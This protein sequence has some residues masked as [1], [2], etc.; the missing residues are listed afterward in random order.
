[1][2]FLF[3]LLIVS[4]GGV[5]AALTL[6]EW[7]DLLFIAGPGTIVSLIL[8]QITWVR[9]SRHKAQIAEKWV[10]L[11]GSNVMYWKDETPQIAT[12]LEVTRDLSMRGFTPAVIF[13]ASAGYRIS[14]KYLHDSGFAL[15]LGLPE[16]RVMVVP[17]GTPADPFILAVA[18]DH[19]ARVV[20]NDKYRDWANGFPQVRNPGFLIKGGFRSGKL[21][22]DL[23]GGTKQVA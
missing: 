5:L 4:L 6:P 23:G 22:L 12:V 9:R 7:S 20:T 17:K 15:L 3:L 10:I 1:M 8:L 19:R 16:A 11:D 13:D 2:P 18:R 21:W 14:D